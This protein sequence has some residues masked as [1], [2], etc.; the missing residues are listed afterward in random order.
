MPFA[1]LVG[2]VGVTEQ[3][4]REMEADRV[5]VPDRSWGRLMN[6]LNDWDE[7]SRSPFN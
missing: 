4:G 7:C 1:E 5:P 2:S 3:E 6:L